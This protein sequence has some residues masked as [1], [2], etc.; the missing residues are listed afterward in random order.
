MNEEE[1]ARLEEEVRA[2]KAR[3]ANARGPVPTPPRRSARKKK[4]IAVRAARRKNR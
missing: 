3:R 1:I 2:I 4:R